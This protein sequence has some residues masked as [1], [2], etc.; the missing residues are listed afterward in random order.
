M[1]KQFL[2]IHKWYEG[3]YTNITIFKFYA[4]NRYRLYKHK[5]I[6]K[7]NYTDDPRIVVPIHLQNSRIIYLYLLVC[8][9]FFAIPSAVSLSAW[10][11]FPIKIE[12][13]KQLMEYSRKNLVKHYSLYKKKK[14]TLNWI[15]K[16]FKILFK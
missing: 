14:T 16:L 13:I 6:K 8:F 2:Q 1:H 4:C 3:C 9:L 5:I 15:I 7:K 11:N 10:Y 12:T